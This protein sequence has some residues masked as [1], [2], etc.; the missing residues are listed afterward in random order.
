M[1]INTKQ[2]RK[3]KA[4]D[5]YTYFQDLH[6]NELRVSHT[7][8]SPKLRADLAALP[9]HMYEAGEVT[10]EM[11]S[12]KKTDL[13][14]IEALAAEKPTEPE[15]ST[16]AA[17]VAEPPKSQAEMLAAGYG[18]D[19]KAPT[20]LYEVP[21]DPTGA[22]YANAYNKNIEAHNASLEA[23]KAPASAPAVSRE[24]QAVAAPASLSDSSL[25]G[26]TAGIVPQSIEQDEMQ[27]MQ[28]AQQ[29]QIGGIQ[30]EANAL[31]QQAAIE[32]KALAESQKAQQDISDHFQKD[33]AALES[34][35][36]AMFD[37]IK[38]GHI[39]PNR[40][41]KNMSTVG[42]ISTIIGL[43]GAGI[44]NRPGEENAVMKAL[45]HQ[46]DQDIDA[47]KSDLSNK[48]NMLTSLSQQ[49]GSVRAGAE[50]MKNLQLGIAAN[51][52]QQ[53]AAQFK[54]PLVRA[55]ADQ[56]IGALKQQ[57]VGTNAKL[58]AQQTVVKLT[59]AA[60]KDPSKIPELIA[61]IRKVNPEAAK[62]AEDKL[63]SGVGFAND[64]EGAVKLREAKTM[65]DGSLWSLDQLKAINKMSAAEKARPSV[66]AQAETLSQG[67]VG[68]LRPTILGPG[69]VDKNERKILEGIAADPTKV[70]SL[71]SSNLARYEALSKKMKMD[72]AFQ[73]KNNGIN[74]AAPVSDEAK[75]KAILDW[76]KAHPSN[77]K[78]KKILKLQGK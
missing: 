17:P 69:V 20:A 61:A 8:L 46:I 4:D 6:K 13:E 45:N 10:D 43:I 63:V 15:A 29:Q 30:K 14:E 50:V 34:E 22:V 24:P 59:Q 25:T 73:A 18:I 54:D 33:Y 70:F 66:V 71:S 31:A 9:V 41:Y 67:L 39:D 68:L 56:M 72:F 65:L 53:A 47:Q 76:A 16:P 52:I 58:A 37:D 40:V 26:A 23:A 21:A 11:A 55:K 3:V 36:R 62:Q 1:K 12:K 19:T 44:A 60:N 5:R 74:V 27:R 35:Q 64:H 32:Q 78:A 2:W 48:N 38:A 57:M 7:T 28:G 51:K 75:T 77:E 42:K 49:M